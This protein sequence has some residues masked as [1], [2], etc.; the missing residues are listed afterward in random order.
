MATPNM[1]SS[2]QDIIN[3]FLSGGY[4]S[5]AQANPYRVD[6]DPFKLPDPV[7]SSGEDSKS[8]T[9]PCPEG[10]IYDPVIK[11]CVPIDESEQSSDGNNET[12]T[13]DE[14]RYNQMKRDNSTIFGASNTLD[15]YLIDTR[16]SDDILLRFDPSI[17]SPPPIF[18]LGLLDTLFGGD[19]R[20]EDKFNEAMQT[21]TDAGYAK[22][23]NDGTFQVY[24]PQQYYNTVKDNLLGNSQVTLSG[25]YS[26]IPQSVS[27][28]Q[29]PLTVEQAV[30]SV[31]NPTP[32][33]GT[34]EGS[35][36]A[37]DLTGGLLG[38]SP[39]TTVDSQGNR[40]RNDAVYRSNVAK[41]IERNKRNFGNSRFK[42]GFGFTGG[43]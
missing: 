9:D 13:A 38:T 40:K 26:G 39:L 34:S 17:G 15:D 8:P 14:L 36:I 4:A 25:G 23:R 43:R 19:K 11:S 27:V 5:E 30:E 41:N 33:S 31:M 12:P 3:N 18:G 22:K 35:P 21:Y 7:D 6:V 32:Q 29:S 16:G 28:T 1:P 24:N 2:A 42:E 20:R 37:E 10:Y